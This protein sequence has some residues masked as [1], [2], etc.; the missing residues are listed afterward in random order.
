MSDDIKYC[1]D[2]EHRC[3]D[4]YSVNYTCCMVVRKMTGDQETCLNARHDQCGR[5]AKFF[6][7]IEAQKCNECSFHYFLESSKD[8]M[9][10]R[11]KGVIGK[12][13]TC[14]EARSGECGI[15]A[16][17][18]DK[19]E[20]KEYKEVEKIGFIRSIINMLSGR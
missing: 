17:Y 19:Y 2:C 4:M 5:E 18:F 16:K 9:C 12:L 15:E 20:R 14:L 7:K 11:L 13:T 1:S 10:S 6:K 8:D 3:N